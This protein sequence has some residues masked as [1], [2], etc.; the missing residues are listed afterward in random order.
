MDSNPSNSETSVDQSPTFDYHGY[1]VPIQLA[2]MT[3]G[4]P[5]TFPPIA[6]HHQRLLRHWIELGPS[7]RVL[8][9]GCGIGR[10]AIPLGEYLT[11]GSYTGVDVIAP[12]IEWLKTNVAPRNPRF[13]FHHS[14]VSD[15][16]H[17]P[18][19]SQIAENI[20][21]PAKNNSID[22]IFLFSV[23]TH[24][25][26]NEIEHYLSEFRRILAPGGLVFATGF[27]YTPAVLNKAR[28]TDLT[29]WRLA[30]EHEVEDGVRINSPESP[31]GAVA[32]RN[33]V[34][35]DIME[36]SGLEVQAY[37]NGGW[38]G[39]FDDAVDGQDVVVLRM[40]HRSLAERIFQ[41]KRRK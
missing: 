16:L 14:N 26:K 39:Y 25:F 15:D 2:E 28:Q 22:K 36:S 41:R 29:P 17:N 37:L 1:D 34:W 35:R 27:T 13:T 8:E 5:D 33:D 11:S 3:G 19:G 30:F 32:F 38:S 6:D 18:T 9:L 24:M 31:R 23:F 4:G 40:P 7:D 10:D 20:K 21:L 12:S